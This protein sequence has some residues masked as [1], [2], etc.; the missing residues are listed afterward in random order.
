MNL[1]LSLIMIIHG[2]IHLM[3]FAKAFKLAKVKEL[4]QP[5]SKFMGI[6]WLVGAILFV[7]A[8]AL[9]ISGAK[10]WWMVG[11]PAVIVSQF[12]IINYWKDAKFG[13]IANALVLFV[14]A[15]M[16]IQG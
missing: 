11:F 10:E 7:V 14:I 4:T 15:W 2:L 5:I 3:G 12:L 8:F 9:S 16:F 6:L 1:T 13:T